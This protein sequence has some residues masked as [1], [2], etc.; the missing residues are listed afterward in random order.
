MCGLGAKV[1]KGMIFGL[2][3]KGRKKGSKRFEAK[4]KKRYDI[5]G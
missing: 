1:G 2:I 4:S 3:A 5:L